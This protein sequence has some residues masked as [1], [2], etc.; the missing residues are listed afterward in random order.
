M[1]SER[2]DFTYL[3]EEDLIK[4]GVMN[5]K[6]CVE[7]MGEVLAL[8][9]QGDYLMGGKDNNSHGIGMH[10]P[11]EP[12]FK[13]MPK[14]GPDRRYMAMPAYLGGR[15]HM[16]GQKWYGSNKENTKKGLPRSILM[17]TLNDVETGRP[18]AYMS[19]NLISAMRTGA[20][21]MVAARY[22]AKEDASTLALI[23]AG[24]IATT[25]LICCMAVR[26]GIKTIK[27]KGSSK[28]SKTAHKLKEFIE[29]KYPSVEEIIICETLEECVKD[30]DIINEAVSVN[31]M[32][33]SPLIKTE[34]IKPGAVIL[35]SM[36]LSFEKDF[37][38][39]KATKVVDNLI[40]Y[41]EFYDMFQMMEKKEKENG[42]Y[43]ES[44]GTE[45]CLGVAIKKLI[46]EEQ[47]KE[48]DVT[49]IGQLVDGT[50]KGRMSDDEIFVVGC[51]GMPIEDIGWGH[52][53]FNR[54][55]D[56]GLGTTLNLWEKPYLA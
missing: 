29:E 22:L 25:C 19:G 47:I 46:K 42:E 11:K 39:D 1:S 49:W 54:A 44:E 5:G 16:V 15:F 26:P 8:C 41:D 52:T 3:S 10:F 27:I 36:N 7:I 50:K 4:A 20:V 2:I 30:A 45:R 12:K 9:S 23:G 18:V 14:Q 55:K 56:M 31:N 13:G 48:D 53:L 17:I 24:V 32:K 40:T 43:K 37:L 51:I 33:D 6:E 21:P 28:N 35:S 34:W 38:K